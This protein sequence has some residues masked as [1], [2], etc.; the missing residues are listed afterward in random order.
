MQTPHDWRAM[1][2]AVRHQAGEQLSLVAKD[3]KSS[4]DA[5]IEGFAI[6]TQDFA[7]RL[8]PA[9]PIAALSRA[10]C[11]SASALAESL[12]DKSVEALIADGREIV[13][14]SP[15]MALAIAVA[16]GFVLT[17]IFNATDDTRHEHQNHLSAP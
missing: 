2:D 11:E 12:K 5:V 15:V 8:D 9:S 6:A 7:S 14:Q 17:R 4:V 3:G 13:R 16:S 10:A 1:V